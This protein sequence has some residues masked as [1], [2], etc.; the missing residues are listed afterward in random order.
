MTERSDIFGGLKESI[1]DS[2]GVWPYQASVWTGDMHWGFYA[3]CYK[4]GADGLVE[5]AVQIAQD[6]VVYPVMF[7]YRHSIELRMKHLIIQCRGYL[8]R[9]Y[10]LPS[11]MQNHDLYGLWSELK[12]LFLEIEDAWQLHDPPSPFFLDMDQ[13]IGEFHGLDES[14]FSFRYPVDKQNEPSLRNHPEGGSHIDLLQVKAVVT[15]VQDWLGAVGDML[16]DL[17][18][19][20]P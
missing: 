2:T 11:Q 6:A 19:A 7:L 5:N 1:F 10:C 15:A 9:G 8:G 18:S 20:G 3:H 13:R 17:H 14:S 4:E 12:G 16:D